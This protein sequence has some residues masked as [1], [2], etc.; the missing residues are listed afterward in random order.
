LSPIDLTVLLALSTL[1]FW[2]SRTV[3]FLDA[4]GISR[5]TVR[6][7]IAGGAFVWI[8]G[9]V[10][11]VVHYGLGVPFEPQAMFDSV[12]VQTTIA[13]LWA[14]TG[15]GCMVAG[16]KRSLRPL[17]A[18]GAGLMGAVVLKLFLVDLSHTGTVSRI[19]SFIGVGILLL[20][21]GYF[22]PVPPRQAQE[23]PSTS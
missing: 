22:S 6:A 16:T 2:L 4:N 10:F 17:W 21:V 7:A 13:V 1:L 9:V 19:V 12:V 18:A 11:R 3:L 5:T 8:H 23:E 15:L 20:V 14:L